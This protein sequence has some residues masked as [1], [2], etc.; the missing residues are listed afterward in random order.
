VRDR[1]R[2]R[3]AGERRLLDGSI[4]DVTAMHSAID[5]LEAARAHADHLA[6]TD[7]LTGVANRRSL[8]GLLA[9]LEGRSLGLL[10]LDVDRFKQINDI[11]GHAAGDAVLTELADRLRS[12]LRADDRI[13]RMGGEEFL[14]L[15][16]GV[17]DETAVLDVAEKVRA[18]VSNAP[19][20]LKGQSIP[21][22]VSI[23]ATFAATE[24][25]IDTLLAVADRYMY[26]A[27]RAG[28]NR[29]HFAALDDADPGASDDGADGLRL[30]GAM[31]TVAAAAAGMPDH[32]LTAVSRLAARIAR[33]LDARPFEILRCRIAG[34]L[35]DIGDVRVPSSVLTKPAPLNA[36]E[37]KLVR[38]HSE[39][40]EQ[41]V[42]RI[43]ELSPVAGIVRH[44]HERYDGTGYP[45]G[46]AGDSIP[47][48]ARIIA[49]ADTWNAM[50][51]DR[52]YRTAL[53]T[54]QALYQ[55]D[56]AAG[57]QLDPAIVAALRSVLSDPRE[58]AHTPAGTVSDAT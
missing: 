20:R 45:D 28:R 3:R 44:H 47:R 13:V 25:D 32:D 52:P 2:L 51:T 36:Q 5:A 54:P 39:Y 42:A 10:N 14:I 34:L 12:T 4:L 50:T 21:V 27:K 40:G 8:P 17:A 41:L 1:G 19:V 11:G 22:T 33:R 56:A 18:C 26:A 46:L 29:V 48:E 23:G 30:A 58:Q 31:A 37:W 16:P 9:G 7:A 57:S 35:C 6:R 15:L 53:T 24:Q 38:R 43:P 49:A 55:L